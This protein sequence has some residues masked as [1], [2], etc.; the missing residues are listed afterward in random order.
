MRWLT[1]WIG[2][3]LVAITAS[4]QG[5]VKLDGLDAAAVER[6]I[7]APS[8]KEELA[9]TLSVHFQN[10]VV[11]DINPPDFPVETILK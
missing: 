11:V 8:E 2:L 5:R 7:G 4:A 9:G 1:L 3:T 6:K 10:S